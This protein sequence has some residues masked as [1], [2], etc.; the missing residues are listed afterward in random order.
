MK[1]WQINLSEEFSNENVSQ[2]E[3]V[4]LISVILASYDALEVIF[5]PYW[6]LALTWLMWP[7]WGRL[8]TEDD[9][10]KEDEGDEHI[11]DDSIDIFDKV[12]DYGENAL[13]KFLKNYI[14]KTVLKALDNPMFLNVL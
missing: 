6:A 4:N 13:N 7:R 11:Y 5:V 12:F 8:P 9:E 14:F 2:Y 3:T 10:D 1:S